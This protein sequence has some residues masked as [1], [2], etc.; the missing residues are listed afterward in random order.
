[1]NPLIN[2]IDDQMNRHVSVVLRE[3]IQ[4]YRE[5]FMEAVRQ[6]SK[7]D[8]ALSQFFGNPQPA[9]ALG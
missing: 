9:P 6:A 2:I 1:M 5:V 3:Q 7:I 4:K 8:E